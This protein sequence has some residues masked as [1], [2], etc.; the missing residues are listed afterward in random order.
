MWGVNGGWLG[1]FYKERPAMTPEQIVNVLAEKL[2]WTPEV[3]KRYAG[4]DNYNGWGR[5]QQLGLGHVNREFIVSL[6]QFDSLV[7]SID[8]LRPVLAKLS[9]KEWDRLVSKLEWEHKTLSPSEDSAMVQRYK[10]IRHVLTL[11][12]EQLAVAIA[13]SIVKAKGP[14]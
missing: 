11:P 13:E 14:Q 8:A 5:N 3:R 1:R 2:G 7:T 10:C 12:P 6:H 9:E 4:V